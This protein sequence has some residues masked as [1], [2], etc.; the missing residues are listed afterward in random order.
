MTLSHDDNTVSIILVL[1]LLSTVLCLM[2]QSYPRGQID[3]R[4]VAGGDSRDFLHVQYLYPEC[5]TV[6]VY[7]LCSTLSLLP[8]RREQGGVPGVGRETLS[9]QWLH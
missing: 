8:S 9:Q 1:L 6:I 4:S 7:H 3:S 5:L 2:L